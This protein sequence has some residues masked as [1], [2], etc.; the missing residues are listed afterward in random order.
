MGWLD[1]WREAIY[2]KIVTKVGTRRYWEDW[3][4]DVATIADRHTTRIRALLADPALGL[5]EQFGHFL[6]GLRCNLNDSISRD[7]AVD[8][9]AQHLI[10]RPVFDALFK[11][12]SFTEHNPVSKVMQSMLD[13]LDEQNVDK[14]AE[15]LEAFYESVRLRAEGID[16][17]EGKQKIITE[18]YEKFF[19]LAFPRA[20]ESLGIVYTPVE[21]VDFIVRSVEQLLRQEFGVSISDAGVHILDPFTGTGTFIVRLLQSGFLQPQDLLR[22]YTKELHANELLLLAYYI[23]AINIEAT[24][25][26]LATQTDPEA[27]Y[28][29]F[30]GIVLTDT[31]QMTEDGA[32]DDQ[33]AFPANSERAARQRD[34]DLRVI[35]ANPP[36]SV[37][38]TSGNDNNA[39]LK[40]PTLD[41]AIASTYAAR[42]TATNKNSLYDSYVRAFRWASDRI[43][44]R[45]IIGF[46]SNGGFIDGNTA[47]GLRMTLA[48][49]F[50]SIYVYNLRGNARTSGE[51]RRKEKDSVFGQGARTAVAIT[52]L[53]KNPEKPRPTEIYYKD[54]GDYL[55]RE[56]KLDIIAHSSVATIDWER[57]QPNDAGDW[58]NQRNASFAAYT[59]IGEKDSG[60]GGAGIFRT[61]S[62]G[63]KTNRDAWV[64]NSAQAAVENNMQATVDFYNAEVERYAV[65]C[66]TN[67]ITDPMAHVN[68]FINTDTKR[69]SW[70]RADKNNLGR[71]AATPK[72]T[73]DQTAIRIGAYRPFNKQHVYFDRRLNDMIYQLPSIFPS[74]TVENVGFVVISPRPSTDFAVLA[75]D[76]IPDLSYFTYAAQFFPRYTYTLRTELE[77]AADQSGESFTRIDNVTEKSL[78]SYRAAYGPEVTKDDVFFYVYGLL[79]SPGYRTQ[80][81]GDLQKT[82]PRIPKVATS[83]DFRAFVAAGR[84]LATLHIRYETIDPYPLQIAGAPDPT[85]ISPELYEYYR[86]EKMRFTGKDRSRVIY[87][88]RITVSGIPEDAHKYLLGSR[89]AIEWVMERYQIRTDKASGIVNDPN[90]WSREVGNPRYILDLLARIVTVSVE[91]VRIVR[92]LPPLALLRSLAHRTPPAGLSWPARRGLRRQHPARR[93][94]GYRPRSRHRA[95]QPGPGPGPCPPGR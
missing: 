57:I 43:R 19:K 72:Y 34:L 17:V 42:S 29:P 30:D 45:G 14:E 91:T 28:V 44:D 12:Y 55:T 76:A 95:S 70:N 35:I 25:H 65:F 58:I 68:A 37:G 82:L 59:R 41:A 7:D 74:A 11:G 54:I 83:E 88:S 48:K 79:H 69:I 47:D 73:Y 26:G 13:A 52:L 89:S 62:G 93:R 21:I 40:Y 15:T 22:K 31:F 20:A 1:E 9:L 64:Y 80:F 50:I 90:D 51:L 71:G 27:S 61:Y 86:V 49:E 39:N 53:V 38:Q 5:D 32:F 92:S 8:M 63:L 85:A 46:V 4:R 16:N 78:S 66:R 36:Y 75:V 2:A 87:N 6:A 94:A 77:E 60:G 33:E 18:L 56:Q 24:Y 81:A 10:T 67:N 3:A 23:A 84:E